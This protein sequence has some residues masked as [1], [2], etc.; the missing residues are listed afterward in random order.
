[1][2]VREPGATRTLARERH[3]RIVHEVKLRSAVRVADLADLLG[4][5]DM[6]IRRDLDALDDAGLV[7]KVHGGATAIV[8]HSSNEPGF[9]TKSLRNTSEKAA[10]AKVAATMVEPGSSV[11][12]SAG[13][14]T[15][16]LAG[17]LL[18][19]ADL[20]VVTNSVRVAEV[21]HDQPRTD[22]TVVL[23][24]GVRTPSDALVGPIAVSALRHMHV[25]T[26]FIGVHGFSVRAG[27][28][29][30]NMLEA[31]TNRAFFAAAEKRVVLADHTKW[32]LTGLSSF[33]DLADADVLVVD[34]ALDGDALD[35]VRTHII[36]VVEVRTTGG[37]ADGSPEIADSA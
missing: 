31:E 19:V 30:P 7:L 37:A 36:R 9:V 34:D 4:V 2:A 25:D 5:S 32:G 1:M 18:D 10:I 16:R 12:I 14:T 33:A 27:F 3:E 11:G 21:F 15:W 24:G 20:T 22:R 17:D 35:L 6:T 28:S 26:L 29:T 13:T 23:T 8:D